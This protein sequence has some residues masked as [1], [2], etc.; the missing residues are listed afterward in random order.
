MELFEVA[1]TKTSEN[2]LKKCHSIKLFESVLERASMN[3]ELFDKVCQNREMSQA[4]ELS[5]KFLEKLSQKFKNEK[6]YIKIFPKLVALS[7]KLGRQS[8]QVK[9]HFKT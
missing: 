4:S 3:I 6:T 7:M 8:F 5:E 2:C 1:L 9:V